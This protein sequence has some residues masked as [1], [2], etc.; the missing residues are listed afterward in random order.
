M[1]R[2]LVLVSFLAVCLV[3]SG[4]LV[5]AQEN[6]ASVVAIITKMENDSTKA[7]RNNDAAFFQKTLADDWTYGWN[8][9]VWWTKAQ[10]LKLVADPAKDK[11]NKEEIS[12][13]KV[14]VYNGDTAVATYT[15]S[16]DALLNGEHQVRAM[17]VTDTFVKS[18]GEWR[19]VASHSCKSK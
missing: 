5:V 3:V 16:Y 18:G 17:L 15:D 13:L 10:F 6:K 8:E 7:D 2:I 12:D 19:A 11:T 4:V 9:G 14:R 1:K